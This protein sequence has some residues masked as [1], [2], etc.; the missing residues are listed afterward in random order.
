MRPAQASRQVGD[1]NATLPVPAG[2]SGTSP[3]TGNG[4]SNGER[5]VGQHASRSCRALPSEFQPVTKPPLRPKR[6]RGTI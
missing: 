1:S 6:N 5:H 4:R 3:F 2:T